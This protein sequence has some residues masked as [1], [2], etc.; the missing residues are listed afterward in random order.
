MQLP[1]EIAPRPNLH[2][3]GHSGSAQSP[4]SRIAP[5]EMLWGF[6]GENDHQIVIAVWAGIPARSGAK[7][8]NPFRVIRPHQPADDLP[9]HRIV[10]RAR[11]YRLRLGVLHY[12]LPQRAEEDPRPFGQ[13]LLAPP[14]PE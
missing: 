3:R 8:V 12:S 2:V 5:P 6:I 14:S 11:L 7:E 10:G 4:V 9:Q 13:P 1:F